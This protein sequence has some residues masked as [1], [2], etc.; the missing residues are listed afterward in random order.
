M[1]DSVL[2]NQIPHNL[3]DILKD[4]WHR[5]IDGAVSSRHPFHC[6]PIATINGEFPEI[7]TVVLRKVIPE[8]KTLIFHTDYRSPKIN[9]IKCNNRTSWLFYDA[10]SRLQLRIKTISAIHHDDQLSLKSWNESTLDSKKCY[11]VQAA[12]S[13]LAD[14]PSDGLPEHINHSSLNEEIVATG[15]ENFAVIRNLVTELDWLFL[16]H[17]GHRRAKFIFGENEVKKYWMIP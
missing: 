12:P 6:S 3:E 17:D 10:K 1:N 8:E 7:R 9:Q 4:C 2:I 14:Y 13:T 5:L 11:L 16:N 15:I